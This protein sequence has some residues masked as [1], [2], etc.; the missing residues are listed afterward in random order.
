MLCLSVGYSQAE[1]I[2]SR[3]PVLWMSLRAVE[4]DLAP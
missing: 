2:K 1:I 4:A 3:I